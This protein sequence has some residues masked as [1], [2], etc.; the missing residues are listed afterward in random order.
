[1]TTAISK[2]AERFALGNAVAVLA[3][4]PTTVDDFTDKHPEW[5][6]KAKDTTK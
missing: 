3:A 1:M 6:Q 5:L 2:L 4:M